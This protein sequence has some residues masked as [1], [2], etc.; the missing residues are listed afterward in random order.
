MNSVHSTY[1][2]GVC[3]C[4][5]L[6]ICM[7]T[8]RGVCVDSSSDTPVL[9]L[10]QDYSHS[11]LSHFLARCAYVS[12]GRRFL[13]ACIFTCLLGRIMAGQTRIKC[14]V[15]PDVACLSVCPLVIIMF[16]VYHVRTATTRGIIRTSLSA[17]PK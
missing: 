8:H 10:V 4:K 16:H 6:N 7:H 2:R 12:A 14:F 13:H 15:L 9:A 5:H 17:K 3:I 11:T 1:S